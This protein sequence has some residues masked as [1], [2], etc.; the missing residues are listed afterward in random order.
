MALGVPG[1]R[2]EELSAA[3]AILQVKGDDVG[4]PQLVAGAAV[5][6]GAATTAAGNGGQ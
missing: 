2:G 1:E 3:L 6:A 4:Q 5:P